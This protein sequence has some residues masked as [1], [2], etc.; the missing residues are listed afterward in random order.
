MP[1]GAEK[2]EYVQSRFSAIAQKYDVFN[3][4]ITQGFHRHWKNIVV[5][6]TGL[7]KG[8]QALDI[9]C[10]TGDITERLKK[11]VGEQ[12][13]VTG[14]D[15]SFG[16]LEVARS[17]TGLTDTSLVQGDAM[18]LPFANETFD[19]VTVGYGLRNLVDLTKGLEEV[20]RVLKPGGRFVCLDLGKVTLPV[21]KQIFQFYFFQVVP[22]IG[23][24]LYPN[25]DMFDY[26]PQSS[27]A[28]P[29]PE[30]LKKM[31]ENAGF[32][33]VSFQNY[34]FGGSVIHLAV[35]PN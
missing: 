9:C 22:R 24:V 20:Y 21:A 17:R 26:F 12:G 18:N 29:G 15:F 33:E 35:K 10:G 25:E 8:G 3:D 32:T 6:K 28:Y 7:A 11:K 27:V 31:L 14:M 23:K 5:K 30:S 13:Q 4:L 16:M 2:Y 19:A 1:D 34:H